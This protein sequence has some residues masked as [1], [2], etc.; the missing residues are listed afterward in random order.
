MFS[1]KKKPTTGRNNSKKR[2]RI[3]LASKKV[4]LLLVMAIF[5]ALGGGYYLYSSSAATPMCYQATIGSGSSEKQCIQKLQDLLRI[6]YGYGDVASDGSYGPKTK[7]AVLAFEKSPQRCGNGCLAATAD[8]IADPTTGYHICYND[9][10]LHQNVWE[11]CRLH[12][13]GSP[14][15]APQKPTT[16]SGSQPD[17]TSPNTVDSKTGEGSLPNYRSSNIS[18]GQSVK[19]MHKY[20]PTFTSTDGQV[21]VATT[22]DTYNQPYGDSQYNW[23]VQKYTNGKW[24]KVAESARFGANK[25]RDYICHGVT[26]GGTYRV[27]FILHSNIHGTYWVWGYNHK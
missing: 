4:Q 12:T 15:P 3:N 24:A 27:D 6:V 8:G 7:A 18:V 22:F 26:K 11:Y 17:T 9:V 13:G 20:T 2:S 1:F 10:V 14:A 21:C 19:E 23:Q 16:G 25:N 5:A